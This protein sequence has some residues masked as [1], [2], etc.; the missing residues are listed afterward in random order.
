V[1]EI[2]KSKADHKF[3]SIAKKKKKRPSYI[4]EL[5]PCPTREKPRKLMT[6]K[7]KTHPLN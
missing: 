3:P 7:S 5:W 2:S 4:R 6:K 1:F